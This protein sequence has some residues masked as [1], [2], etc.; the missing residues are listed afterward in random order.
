MLQHF[1]EVTGGRNGFGAKLT[2]IFSKKFVVETADSTQGKKYR[3]SFENNMGKKND[4]KLASHSGPDY[5]KVCRHFVV[6]SNQR[7]IFQ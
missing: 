7:F 6:I 1:F 2:N 4:P 5:T 3:Q